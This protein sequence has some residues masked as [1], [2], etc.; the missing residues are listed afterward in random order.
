VVWVGRDLKDH[1][2]PTLLPGAGTPSTRPSCSRPHP[3]WPWTL[4]WRGQPQLDE[5]IYRRWTKRFIQNMHP[6]V[7]V[8]PRL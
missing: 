3:A 6:I 4:P 1:L 2:V 8:V 5:D 7:N